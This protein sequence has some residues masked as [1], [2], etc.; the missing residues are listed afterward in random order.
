MPLSIFKMS[1]FFA[2]PVELSLKEHH[3]LG[4]VRGHPGFLI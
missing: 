1:C 2:M 3:N 4:Q